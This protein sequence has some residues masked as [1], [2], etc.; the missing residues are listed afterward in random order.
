MSQATA[1]IRTT[2]I[3]LK[4]PR[5]IVLVLRR[6]ALEKEISLR[7]VCL[8]AFK[9]YLARNKALYEKEIVIAT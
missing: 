8:E 5:N 7:E 1:T 3:D 9:E 2:G 6:C 4:C